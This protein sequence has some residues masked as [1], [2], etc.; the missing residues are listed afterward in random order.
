MNQKRP[1][2]ELLCHNC[3]KGHFAKVCIFQQ[4][5][6]QEIEEFAETEEIDENDTDKSINIKTEIKHVNDQ[7]YH[8]AMTMKINVTEIEIIQG[9][10]LAR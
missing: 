7:K 10:L 9:L 5:K 6:K 4:Q 3:K 2:R 1:T 8:I